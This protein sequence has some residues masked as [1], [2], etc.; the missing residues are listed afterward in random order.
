[1][2]RRQFRSR[3]AGGSLL[4]AALLLSACSGD[5]GAD[6]G[7]TTSGEGSDA[8]T[9]TSL[10]PEQRRAAFDD[11]MDRVTGADDPDAGQLATFW[12][13]EF[14]EVFGD[15]MT[16]VA[17][18]VPFEGEV[19]TGC[20][21]L[22]AGVAAYCIE[23]ER[24][25]YD[26]DWMLA[27]HEAFGDAGP[28]LVLAHEV[29]HH[30]AAQRGPRP[31]PVAADIQADC[32]AGTFFDA[33]FD[34]TGLAPGEVAG[35][36]AA[37]YVLGA[38]AQPEDSWF[39]GELKG[40]PWW[41]ARAFLDGATG[42]T[43]A[44]VAYDEWVHRPVLDVGA[45]R[46]L[47]SRAPEVRRSADGALRVLDG[48]TTT[49]VGSAPSP[50]ADTAVE[51]VSEIAAAWF[52]T[53]DPPLLGEPIAVDPH[54]PQGASAAVQGYRYTDGDGK[55]RYGMLLVHLPAEGDAAVVSTSREG[56]PPEPD[57][58]EGWAAVGVPLFV[59]AN[60]LCPPGGGSPVCVTPSDGG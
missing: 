37:T 50:E 17:G 35:T 47:P 16:W 6:T 5:G 40:D 49:V 10:S 48:D 29:G 1:M 4:V 44:C 28:A 39:A 52:D 12:T 14:A 45:W 51:A 34:G 7:S 54:G 57:D 56:S 22:G 32:L 55:D 43:R 42:G 60:G 46:W 2:P 26:L 27:L 11:L 18:F 38:R 3:A 36:T 21:P 59:T 24:V 23:D 19:E 31:E 9:T 20:G 8:A 25:Y 58:A 15:E 13:E 53:E 33:A 30:I 41:R